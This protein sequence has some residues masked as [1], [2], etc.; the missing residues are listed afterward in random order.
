ML[1][2]LALSA[3]AEPLP[4]CRR[5]SGDQLGWV[6]SGVFVGERLVLADSTFGGLHSLLPATGAW[7]THQFSGEGPLEFDRG[8]LVGGGA[9]GVLSAVER[10]VVLSSALQPVRGV[11]LANL[12]GPGTAAFLFQ[13]VVGPRDSLL[14]YL[15]QLKPDGRFE[16][17]VAHAR[18]GGEPAIANLRK[19][20]REASELEY[21]RTF[22]S[23]A[24]RLGDRLFWLTMASP[25]HILEGTA[26]KN[27][28]LELVPAE[29]RDVP[30][31]R[32]G[33]PDSTIRDFAVLERQS[34]LAGLYGQGKEL[35]I[36]HRSA[37]PAGRVRWQLAAVDPDHPERTRR[38]TLPTDSPWITLVPGPTV[39]ALLEQG[40]VDGQLPSHQTT[41]S[42]LLLPSAWFS[43][44]VS[45][46]T[47]EPKKDLC[48]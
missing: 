3:R 48:P 6:H 13:G 25:A 29:W 14:G 5:H 46:L 31:I 15:E 36:L 32:M 4:N 8:M 9:E 23:F 41:T 45:P 27:R 19:V 16:G 7:A 12:G 43:A 18:F 28:Q 33:G 38:L 37:L 1:V 20:E 11:S 24:A 17:G 2:L 39:W 30:S 26:G 42:V 10:L 34:F 44:P 35:F 21:Y 47:R 40:P 22:P